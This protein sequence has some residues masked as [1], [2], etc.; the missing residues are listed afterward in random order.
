LVIGHCFVGDTHG[1]AR[2]EVRGL[3]GIGSQVEIGE[4]DVVASH[5]GALFGLWLFDFDDHLGVGEHIGS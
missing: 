3:V 5:H 4:Q 1:T 2:D